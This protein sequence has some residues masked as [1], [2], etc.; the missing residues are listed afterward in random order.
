[1]HASAYEQMSW[2]IERYL[3][4]DRRYHVVDFG[5]HASKR[6]R[7]MTHRDLLAGHDC[8]ITGVDVRPGANVDVVM[9]RPY[10][11][12]LRSN[13]VD[14]VMSG[15]VFEHIPFFWASMLEISRVLRRGGL[16]LVTMPSRG[17][18][19]T[20][21][22]CWRYYPDGVRA[23]AAFAGLEVREVY[24]D[25]PPNTGPG[26]GGGRGAR[27][28][29][30]RIDM[31]NRY[32]GD[33]VGVLEKTSRYPAVPLLLAR[34]PILWWANRAAGRLVPGD[35][36]TDVAAGDR[37]GPRTRAEGRPRPRTR[38]PAARRSAS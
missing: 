38:A 29:Y 30:A 13:S 4:K 37:P 35:R 16:F 31:T 5:S 24:T 28:R 17:H 21:V 36:A 8:R 11:V 18:M 33:T 26:G 34:R 12:P 10:R 6:R 19:H 9:Q 14:V 27:H 20:S 32:W 7:S 1:M 23:M 3:P 2:C 15:Q 22:D 25:F